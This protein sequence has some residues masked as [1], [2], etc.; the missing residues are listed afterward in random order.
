MPFL[1]SVA[2]LAV[3]AF[4]LAAIAAQPPVPLGAASSFAILA[5]TTIT[6]SG[7]TTVNGSAGGDIGLFPGTDFPGQADVAL[8]GAVHIADTEAS[9]AQDALVAAYNNAA[10]RTPVTRIAAQLGGQTLTPGVYDTAS[11]AFQITGTLTLDGE[12]AADPVFVFLTDSTLITASGSNVILRNGARYCRTF[13]KVGSSATLGTNSHFVGHIFA[14]TSITANTGA[15]IQGQLLAR[16][17]AVSLE[18]NTI[19]NGICAAS[20]PVPVIRIHKDADPAEASNGTVLVTYTYT[21]TNGGTLPLTDVRVTDDKIDAVTYVSGDT[22]SDET[23][24]SDETWIYTASMELSSSTTNVATARGTASG[25]DVTDSAYVTVQVTAQP[26]GGTTTT[27]RGGSL[28][29]TATP[30]YTLLLVGIALIGLG[31]TGLWARA[32]ERRE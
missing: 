11:G 14:L 19:T 2:L 10:G 1:L 5:G 15:S 20:G 26:S 30:W 21:V 22:N 24:Q 12:G 16:N 29:H 3:M 9:Q 8:S 7:P 4:P 32:R 18:R 17:G 6:N 27:V 13:W 25:E 28:P 23:L 31:S